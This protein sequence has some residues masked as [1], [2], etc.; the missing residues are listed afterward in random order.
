MQKTADYDLQTYNRLVLQHQD[1]AFTLAAHLLG[2]DD[3]AGKVVGETFRKAFSSRRTPQQAFRL[4]VLRQVV[5]CCQ[6]QVQKLAGPSNLAYL[7]AGLADEEKIVLALVDCL[8][9]GYH[10]CA[11]VLGKKSANIMKTLAQARYK[12]TGGPS[13]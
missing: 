9:L 13:Q 10:D 11:V 5:I 6:M 2:D 12:I 3:L 4:E 7:L 1:E 8:G